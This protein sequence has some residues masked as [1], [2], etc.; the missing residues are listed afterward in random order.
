MLGFSRDWL[1]NLS[2]PLMRTRF[3]GPVSGVKSSVDLDRLFAAG[4]VRRADHRDAT[5]A[6]DRALRKGLAVAV[7]PG[8]YV[9]A[10]L[11]DDPDTLKRA[12]MLWDPDAVVVGRAA[13]E[14]SFWPGLHRATIELASPRRRQVTSTAFRFV[15][16]TVPAEFIVTVGGIRY[17]TPALTAIDL[18]TDLGATVIDRA[19]RAKRVTPDQ[20]ES[21]FATLPGR[22]G[23]AERRRRILDAA[24]KPW[25]YLE[26]RTHRL[27]RRNG[28]E[29]WQGN[30]TVVLDGQI[31][32]PDVLF[33]DVPLVLELEGPHHKDPVVHDNDCLRQNDFAV[34]G[35]HVLRFTERHIDHEED[36][37]V[38]S[39][40]DL[41]RRLLHR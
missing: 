14:A 26:R 8:V 9:P 13:A 31:Y 34:A 4:A 16:R 21:V 20:L 27:L 11:G 30:P 38:A 32:H 1:P 19:F 25:S 28:L 12:A 7:L 24:G 33:D 2:D 17:S 5:G 41:R 35:Y 3:S 10:A 40:F 6:L 29:G 22:S 15:Q 23:N 37:V 36:R 18:C 39:I